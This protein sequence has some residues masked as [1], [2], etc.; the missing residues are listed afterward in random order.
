MKKLALT[1]LGLLVFSVM[2]FSQS[3]ANDIPV[4]DLPKEV[5]T[6]LDQ[7]VQIL[8][9]ENLDVCAKKF[10]EV[11]GGAL[12]NPAGTELR[13][14]KKEYSL[15]KDFENIKFYSQPVVISRVNKTYSNGQ[16]YGASAIKG[17]V[18]KIW[19]DKTNPDFG[20]PAPISILVPENHTTI[21]TPKVVNI[22][23]F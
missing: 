1:V 21:K 23:S 14:G 13:S 8:N 9:S 7:Y 22:G 2:G 4:K 10:M 15:K 11:A 3:R 16:G 6:V 12:V 17:Y 20:R 5:K 19:I 18:Y